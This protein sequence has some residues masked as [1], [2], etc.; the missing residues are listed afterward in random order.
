[1][2]SEARLVFNFRVFFRN[3]APTL[4]SIARFMITRK[5]IIISWLVILVVVTGG[6]FWYNEWIYSLP[7]P[8]PESYKFVAVNQHISAVEKLEVPVG[9]PVFLHFFNP[10]CPCSRFNLPHFRELVK[11]YGDRVTFVAVPMIMLGHDY[12]DEEIREK[13]DVDIPV[14]RQPGL[15]EAVGVYSTPQAVVLNIN[16]DLYYRGNYNKSRYCTD[17]RSNY[18]EMAIASLLNNSPTPDFGPIALR[19]YG[20]TIEGCTK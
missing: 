7:T 20:C 2:V 18:A 16:K 6:L 9:K 10:D 14:L 19:A 8:V 13:L 17:K 3:F 12:T 15:A 1:M 5:G 11:K 4:L